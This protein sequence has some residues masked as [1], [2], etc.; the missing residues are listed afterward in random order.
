MR[1]LSAI[2]ADVAKV[3]PMSPR[4]RDLCEGLKHMRGLDDNVVLFG[5]GIQGTG[6]HLLRE[7]GKELPF[8][9]TEA[10]DLVF[11]EILEILAVRV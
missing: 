10:Q 7:L 4:M 3:F 6:H 9:E 11:Q 1:L 2:A 8:P 5:I